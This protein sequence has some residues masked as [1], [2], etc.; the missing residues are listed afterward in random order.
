ME[1]LQPKLGKVLLVLH[2]CV[3]FV[4]V[5]LLPPAVVALQGVDIAASPKFRMGMAFGMA[6]FALFWNP[7]FAS[8]FRRPRRDLVCRRSK[9]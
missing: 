2:F 1:Q 4:A 5:V 7:R 8:A 9:A 3:L 6:N